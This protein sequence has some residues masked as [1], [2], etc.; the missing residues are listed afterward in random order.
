MN[1][2]NKISSLV[3]TKK[4]ARPGS[5]V[6]RLAGAQGAEG[7][8]IPHH[9]HPTPTSP[10]R[11]RRS[12]ADDVYLPVTPTSWRVIKDS[13]RHSGGLW[14]PDG[15]GAPWPCTAPAC[16]SATTMRVLGTP[17]D[18]HRH[19]GTGRIFKGSTRLGC[20]RPAAHQ[21]GGRTE[22]GHRLSHHRAGRVCPGRPGQLR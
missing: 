11:R 9:P 1:K 3:D 13:R 15:P 19:R 5:S 16:L 8:G 21:P 10:C 2:P 12:L 22:G 18:H 14:R 6:F 20:S 4:L 7:R 17:C